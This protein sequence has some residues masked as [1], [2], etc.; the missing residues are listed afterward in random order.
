MQWG[1]NVNHLWFY[2]YSDAPSFF[3]RFLSFGA[4]HD[5]PFRR[6]VESPR[7]VNNWMRSSPIN[8]IC[9]ASFLEA[10]FCCW[11]T[12]SENRGIS[13]QS[14]SETLQISENYWHPVQR[15]LK[16]SIPEKRN[17]ENCGLSCQSLLEIH[18]ISEMVWYEMHQYFN[19]L[20]NIEGTSLTLKNQKRFLFSPR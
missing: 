20:S 12:F 14:F 4:F 19:R 10:C 17:L 1:L 11:R 13:C 7:R 5:K 2:N 15:F 16:T 6:F 3:G 8:C 9:I 18:R